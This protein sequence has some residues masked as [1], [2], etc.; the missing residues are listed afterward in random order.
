P[1]ALL[2]C[3]HARVRRRSMTILYTDPIFLRHDTGAHPENAGR[4]RAITAKLEQTG[5]AARCTPG[6]FAPLDVEQVRLVPAPSL[7][8]LAQMVA[9]QGGGRI[10]VDP[11]VCPES[12]DVA[13]SAAGA[14]SAAV[15][16]VLD[17]PDKTA[18][19]LVRPPGHH[20]TPNRSMGF[21][22]FN[23]VALAAR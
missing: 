7:G 20:A 19:C 1:A 15:D 16:A 21:C 17:G 23:N 5:L 22:L 4:L 11:V 14:A 18:L 10:D 8:G 6:T 12:S 2:Q 13:L 9:K 3:R